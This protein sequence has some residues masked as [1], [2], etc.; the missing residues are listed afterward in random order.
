MHPR[1][2]AGKAPVRRHRSHLAIGQHQITGSKEVQHLLEQ[3]Q[4]VL[5][6]VAFDD[7]EQSTAGKAEEANQLQQRAQPWLCSGP[8]IRSRRSLLSVDSQGQGQ[9][10]IGGPFPGTVRGAAAGHRQLASTPEHRPAHAGA[11]PPNDL[12][13]PPSPTKAQTSQQESVRHYLSAILD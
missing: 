9:D 1:R 11:Q 2:R 5:V 12:R 10:G 8:R 3:G 6:L 13:H 7:V 4:F